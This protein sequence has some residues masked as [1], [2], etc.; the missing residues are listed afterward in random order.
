MS[1]YASVYSEKR[2]EQ[3]FHISETN[4][5][6]SCRNRKEP[7]DAEC[8]V[9]YGPMFSGK[10]QM[11]TSLIN[12]HAVAGDRCLIIG[13]SNDTRNENGTGIHMHNGFHYGSTNHE[14]IVTTLIDPTELS[15]FVQGKIPLPIGGFD[16]IGIDEVQFWKTSQFT[17]ADPNSPTTEEI[18]TMNRY[19]REEIY[20]F[21]YHCND[22]WNV[23]IVVSGLDTWGNGEPVHHIQAFLYKADRHIHMKA[24]CEVCRKIQKTAIMTITRADYNKMNDH[25]FSVDDTKVAPKV[26]P[27]ARESYLPICRVC[28]SRL[29]KNNIQHNP[30]TE[31]WK[32]DLQNM[33]YPVSKNNNN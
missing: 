13:F 22:V 12:D 1:E 10:S 31:A 25:R 2:C 30:Y 8:T 14:N 20:S 6:L 17:P 16:V 23:S 27:G 33:L 18:E 21:K 11:A 15:D 5:I 7:W 26:A 4:G 29:S 28:F 24:I 9:I 3:S 19:I 32:Q